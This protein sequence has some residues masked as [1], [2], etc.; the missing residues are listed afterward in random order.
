MKE[1]LPYP[2]SVDSRLQSDQCKQNH[3]KMM[4][5]YVLDVF[6]FFSFPFLVIMQL[7]ANVISNLKPKRIYFLNPIRPGLFSRS[8]GPRGGAEA[9]MPKIKVDINQLK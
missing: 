7:W 3:K 2:R 9:R 6:I 4:T 1:F 8:P 5:F